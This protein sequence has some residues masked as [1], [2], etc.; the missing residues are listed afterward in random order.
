MQTARHILYE[1]EE[2][3]ELFGHGISY[4]GQTKFFPHTVLFN[5][6]HSYVTTF[7]KVKYHTSYYKYIFSSYAG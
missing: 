5:G 7:K 1:E 4:S 6:M 2:I 3:S